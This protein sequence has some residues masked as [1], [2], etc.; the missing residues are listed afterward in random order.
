[1]NMKLHLFYYKCKKCGKEFKM[2]HLPGD[3]YGDFLMRNKKNEILYINE[4]KDN[5]FNEVGVFFTK[6]M[7]I[8][9]KIN[10]FNE[11]DV[12]Q[13]IFS[14]ACDG[15]TGSDDNSYCIMRDP[16]CPYCW[17]ENVGCWG[18]TEPPEYI[19]QDVKLVTHD[20]WN[21]FTEQEK[22]DAVYQATADYF[23]KENGGK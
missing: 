23:S 20:H 13:T 7:N 12:F 10:E 15:G 18:A 1:M 14:V 3:R 4:F 6:I 2:P 11:S 5:V 19:E 8:F 9:L 22:Y 21:T 17:Q 16:T